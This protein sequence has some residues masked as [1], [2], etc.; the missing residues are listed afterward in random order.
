[1]FSKSKV[2]R[3]K[4]IRR[5]KRGFFFISV[6]IV[7]VA[8]YF[9]IKITH[10]RSPLEVNVRFHDYYLQKQ[11]QLTDDHDYTLVINAKVR[12][13]LKNNFKDVQTTILLL[14]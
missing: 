2:S 9:I 8:V 6:A 5:H 7:T 10:K 11:A 4:T 14:F 3:R 13:L 1:M 12:K